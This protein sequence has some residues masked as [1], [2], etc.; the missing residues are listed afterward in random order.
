MKTDVYW[1]PAR[2]ARA[3]PSKF[4]ITSLEKKVF[5]ACCYR[6]MSQNEALIW[7]EK[8]GIPLFLIAILEGFGLFFAE[9]D[10]K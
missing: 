1:R 2:L 8:K 5:Y 6:T 4:G 9:V 7:S 3:D 10:L